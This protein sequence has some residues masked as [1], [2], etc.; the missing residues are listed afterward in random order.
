MPRLHAVLLLSILTLLL[1]ACGS[2]ATP[3]LMQ[4]S[5]PSPNTPQAEPQPTH[6]SILQAGAMGQDALALVH[7]GDL[8]LE[9]LPDSGEKRLTRFGDVADAHF[10]PDGQLVLFERQGEPI[11]VAGE[12]GLEFRPRS[13][14]VVATGGGEPYRV[15]DAADLPGP[16]G[17]GDC[18]HRRPQH[19]QCLDLAAGQPQCAFHDGRRRPWESQRRPLAAE[20]GDRAA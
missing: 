17:G 8:W 18:H 2:K 20:P 5:T 1:V 14:W 12:A 7:D 19:A 16:V 13:W 10:S 3:L 6:V 4:A 15:L 9:L 11:A